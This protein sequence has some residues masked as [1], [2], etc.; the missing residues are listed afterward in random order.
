MATAFIVKGVS[1]GLLSTVS[2]ATLHTL[3][4]TKSFYDHKTVNVGAII[5]QMGLERRLSLTHALVNRLSAHL[6]IEDSKS[7]KDYYVAQGD[8]VM[9]ALVYLQ[10][11]VQD[12]TVTLDALTDKVDAHSSKWFH[13][14][15]QLSIETLL[16]TL[17]V[18]DASLKD[19]FEE[20]LRL[21]CFLEKK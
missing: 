21:L 12:I 10:R 14:W 4:L 2:K 9:V 13:K 7:G 6:V 15:R 1:S 18:Q 5:R 11:V 16:E 3:S 20:L 17:K 19:Q 8:P